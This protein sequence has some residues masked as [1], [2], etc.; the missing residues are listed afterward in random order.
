MIMQ[1]NFTLSPQTQ[2]VVLN[3]SEDSGGVGKKNNK[4]TMPQYR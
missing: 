3:K 4:I 2:F 1:N